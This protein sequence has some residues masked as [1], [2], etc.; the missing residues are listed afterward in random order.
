MNCSEVKVETLVDKQL[1]PLLILEE[2]DETSDVINNIE[3]GR[4]VLRVRMTD[5][6]TKDDIREV[7]EGSSHDHNNVQVGK[8]ESEAMQ[9]E[10]DEERNVTLESQQDE[11]VEDHAGRENIAKPDKGSPDGT[12]AGPEKMLQ[13]ETQDKLSAQAEVKLRPKDRLSPDDAKL[14]VTFNNYPKCNSVSNC[15]K[16]TPSNGLTSAGFIPALMYFLLNH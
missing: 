13:A 16:K 12:A 15:I 4:T 7:T 8:G 10:I 1:E 6:N 2:G 3:R 11:K 14:A 9:A 5:K